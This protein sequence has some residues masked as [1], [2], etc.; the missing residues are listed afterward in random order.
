MVETFESPITGEELPV[1]AHYRAHHWSAR[2]LYDVEAAHEWILTW[3]DGI[4]VWVEEW[5]ESHVALA[6]LAALVAA[7]ERDVFLVHRGDLGDLGVAQRR[8]EDEV[9]R[10]ISR[11]VQQV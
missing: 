6:R 1:V 8:F 5:H 7:V 2:L 11:T 4:N 10:F 3:T 9:E